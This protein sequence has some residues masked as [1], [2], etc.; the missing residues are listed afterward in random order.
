[1]ISSYTPM[2]FAQIFVVAL[3]CATLSLVIPGCQRRTPEDRLQKAQTLFQNRDLLGATFETKE[4]LKRF[5]NDP[6]SIDAR[7]LLAQIY[8]QE[9]RF[10]DAVTELKIV[11]GKVSQKD[12]RGQFALRGTLEALQQQ[13]RYKEA[14]DAI[15]QYQKEY[16]NDEG[17][18]LSLTVARATV[19]S[20]SEQTTPAREILL[21]L[22]EHTTSP[23]EMELYRDLI[24]Q[25]LM[26]EGDT[27]GAID[28]YVKE[29]QATEKP[30]QRAPMAGRIAAGYASAEDYENTR[31]WLDEAT[32][33]YDAAISDAL[34]ADVRSQHLYDLAS[35]YLRTGNLQGADRIL[36]S[37]F[38]SSVRQDL[39]AMVTND[40]LEVLLRRGKVDEAIAFM[41]EAG[42]H[43]P[44][45]PIAQRAADLEKIKAEGKVDEQIPPDTGTLVL[46]FERDTLLAPENLPT[47]GTATADR[48]T[49]PTADANTAPAA[50]ATTEPAP[51]DQVTTATE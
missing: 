37:L 16:A 39:L 40:Q 20:R 9:R 51:A 10:D 1:M 2:R 46:K 11:L 13:E 6:L 43:F 34:N 14:L 44:Q 26:Q 4:L 49:T 17:L 30:E 3:A 7:L 38:D 21:G 42:K 8:F 29:F 41:R 36:R 22:K 48:A 23:A 35:L 45:S 33:A 27:T 28:F 15:E 25:T 19:L 24:A 31:K 12:P 5:P 50:D 18:S 47:T 32:K